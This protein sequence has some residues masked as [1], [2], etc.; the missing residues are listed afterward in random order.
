MYL[1]YSLE[2]FVQRSDTKIDTIKY[3]LKKD[4]HENAS[5]HFT[6]SLSCNLW[7]YGYLHNNIDTKH[8]VVILYFS[9]V[10]G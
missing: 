1:Y 8:D 3:A 10:A 4:I 7:L 9:R 6:S 2:T 5:F